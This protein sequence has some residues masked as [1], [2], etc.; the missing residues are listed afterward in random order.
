M[1]IGRYTRLD[2]IGR[3]SFATV[4]QG[5]HTVSF[6][7][8]SLITHYLRLPLGDDNAFL[9]HRHLLLIYVENLLENTHVCRHKVG[10]PLEV[11]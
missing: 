3:G 6:A 11:E 8:Y 10:K 1:S 4:Y 5:V 9:I 7:G 2:E